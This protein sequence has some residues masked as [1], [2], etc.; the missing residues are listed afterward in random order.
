M[1]AAGETCLSQGVFSHA[2]IEFGVFP[3]YV[4]TAKRVA[5]HFDRQLIGDF[6]ER[7]VFDLASLTK[8]IVTAPLIIDR[9]FLHR[10]QFAALTLGEVLSPQSPLPERLKT[11]KLIDLLG[12]TS[13]LAPWLNF[14]VNHL[15]EANELFKERHSHIEAVL[16]RASEPKLFTKSSKPSLY[17]DIGYIL[18]GYALETST[19][20][21]L[22]ALFERWLK[23]LGLPEGVDL[24][25]R[26]APA[27][28][29]TT[30]FCPVRQRELIGEVHD[31][32]C[33][34]LGGVSGHAGLFASLP[35]LSLLLPRW[36]VDHR[37][38]TLIEL[39]AD[40]VDG[41]G[42]RRGDDAASTAF[43]GGKAIGHY[44]FTGTSL[45]LCPDTR[46]YSL[47]LTN[48]VFAGRLALSAI[49][50]YR[51][52]VYRYSWSKLCDG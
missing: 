39:T 22:S 23:D 29:I 48:R 27:A 41:M 34:S 43:G 50:K 21:S 45:W 52:E 47:L 49:K 25:F 5:P 10:R 38:Q 15:T 31:E 4:D 42:F 40:S 24:C 19:G 51:H 28:G 7:W 20:L 14:Y 18:L 33:A 35:A 12:H 6:S 13:G 46:R 2:A 3:A 30:G 26:P 37:V 44:G 17:S 16:T 36:Y 11:L 8:L 32:N 9:F 1:A